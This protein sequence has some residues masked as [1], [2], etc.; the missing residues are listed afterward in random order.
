[1]VKA[2]VRF[3]FDCEEAF[4]LAV[5]YALKNLFRGAAT[6]DIETAVIIGLAARV[7]ETWPWR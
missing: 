2:P 4:A 7:L 3:G 1:M 5:T 6:A